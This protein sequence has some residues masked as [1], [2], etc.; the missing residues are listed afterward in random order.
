MAKEESFF[1]VFLIQA[2]GIWNFPREQQ[3]AHRWLCRSFPGFL[4]PAIFLDVYD[5]NTALVLSTELRREKNCQFLGFKYPKMS[6][7]LSSSA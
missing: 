6:M 3:M 5:C 4:F 1:I 2:L 7:V